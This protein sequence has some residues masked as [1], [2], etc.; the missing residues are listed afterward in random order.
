MSR[1]LNVAVAERVMGRCFHVW[2]TPN[3][4][5]LWTCTKC[6]I[7]EGAAGGPLNPRYS[8]E[9]AAAWQVVEKMREQGWWAVVRFYDPDTDE[10]PAH[11]WD[12]H[13]GRYEDVGS[14]VRIRFAD[15]APEAI[16]LAAL[17]AVGAEAKA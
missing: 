15:T 14:V 5:L 7:T 9:I 3:N 1:E 16:C 8:D 11:R 10:N 2:G 17:A 4:G 6:G 12:A 13:F